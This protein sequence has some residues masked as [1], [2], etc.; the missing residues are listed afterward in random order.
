MTPRDDSSTTN[1][2]VHG[3]PLESFERAWLGFCLGFGA[4]IGAG[5]A[6]IIAGAI[7]HVILLVFA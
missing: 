2:T 3:L 4:I 1:V 7:G 5:T 6:V